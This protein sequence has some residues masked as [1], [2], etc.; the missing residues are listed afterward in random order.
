MGANTVLI[1][2][3]NIADARLLEDTLA[4]A[5]DGPFVTEWVR[6]LAEAS[7]RL[8]R[9]GID[10]ILT[11]LFL[12]DSQGL[13]IFDALF[14]LAPLIP[15]MT[16]CEEQNEYLAIEAVQRGAQGFLSKGHFQSAL[17]PQALRNIIQRKRVE[18]AL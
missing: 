2:T 13:D 3:N 18:E 10:I 11:E 1:I 9:R 12:P 14:K 8:D 6:H 4:T 15:I 7:T 5:R 17:V 16:L